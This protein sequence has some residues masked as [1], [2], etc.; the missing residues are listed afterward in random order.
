MVVFIFFLYIYIYIINE[1]FV[2]Q[3]EGTILAPPK[4]KSWPDSSWKWIDF[5]SSHNL[6][7]QGKGIFDGQGFEWWTSKSTPSIKPAVSIIIIIFY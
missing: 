3:V 4:G 5:K 6:T 7:V 2:L 1:N